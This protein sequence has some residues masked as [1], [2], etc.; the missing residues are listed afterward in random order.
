MN[1]GGRR[2]SSP[3]TGSMDNPNNM[4]VGSPHSGEHNYDDGGRSR[5]AFQGGDR[6]GYDRGTRGPGPLAGAGELYYGT[7][8]GPG[9]AASRYAEMDPGQSPQRKTPGPDVQGMSYY[10]SGNPPP[11]GYKT[12]GGGMRSTGKDTGRIGKNRSSSTY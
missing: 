7:H 3:V 4:Q 11:K 5:A 10:K 6:M 2:R 1:R 9:K 12:P 8:G